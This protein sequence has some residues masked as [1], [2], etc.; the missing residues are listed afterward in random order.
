MKNLL[1]LCLFAF[2]LF[3]NLAMFAQPGDQ[4]NVGQGNLEGT[5]PPVAPINTK[6]ILLAIVG[7][8]FV[9]YTLKNRKK[10]A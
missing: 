4:D 2:T 3:S 8:F 7:I 6:L 10:I 9:I 1:K 5:D